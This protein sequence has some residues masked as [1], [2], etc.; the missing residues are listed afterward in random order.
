MKSRT[1]SVGTGRLHRYFLLF[2]DPCTRIEVHHCT[3]N[4]LFKPDLGRL[5]Y[6]NRVNR[7]IWKAG[8]RKMFYRFRLRLIWEK[9]IFRSSKYQF[10]TLHA[11]DRNNTGRCRQILQ[12]KLSIFLLIAPHPSVI[13]TKIDFRIIFQTRV[14]SLSS[15]LFPFSSI[16]KI[17]CRSSLS[18]CQHS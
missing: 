6:I 17:R 9:T 10:I 2:Q 16:Y 8:S 7:C 3:R 13:R 12:L 18:R 4:M 1:W 14:K 15:F 11:I 5:I